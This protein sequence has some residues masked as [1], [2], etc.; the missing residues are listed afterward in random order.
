LYTFQEIYTVCLCLI[1]RYRRL[2]RISLASNTAREF[3][4]RIAPYEITLS[5]V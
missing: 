1:V 4:S 5:S 2:P 3:A